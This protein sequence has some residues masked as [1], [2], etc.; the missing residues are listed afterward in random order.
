[1]CPRMGEDVSPGEAGYT[2]G[3]IVGPN[4]SLGGDRVCFLLGRVCFLVKV[5][6]CLLVEQSVCEILQSSKTGVSIEG[7]V[8]ISCWGKVC[9]LLREG[10]VFTCG[11]D[12]HGVS[13]GQ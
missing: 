9:F 12:E 8:C 13:R 4:T 1:M 10:Q 3:R 11:G 2:W 5:R 6:V 7:V